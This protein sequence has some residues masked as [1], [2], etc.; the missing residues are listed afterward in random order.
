MFG[1]LLAADRL[2]ALSQ[3]GLTLVVYCGLIASLLITLWMRRKPT[4]RTYE[5]LCLYLMGWADEDE[6]EA[7][8]ANLQPAVG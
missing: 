3:N 4:K 2:I 1:V 7:H 5:M 6:M 8:V